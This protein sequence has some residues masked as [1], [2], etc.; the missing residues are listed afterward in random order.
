MESIIR[1]YS[2]VLIIAGILFLP[3]IV[4]GVELTDEDNCQCKGG[5]ISVGDE[6]FNVLA[7]CGNPTITEDW[8]NRWV[9]DR[10]PDEFVL[11]ITFVNDLVARIQNGGY[12]RKSR[13]R[14]LNVS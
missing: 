9:Y 6:R 8:G 11:Y 1:K 5:I 10:G 12:G 2:F 7:K 14:R 4:S 13:Q 3:G